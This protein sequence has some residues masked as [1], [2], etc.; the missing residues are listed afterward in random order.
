MART[1]LKAEKEMI[2]IL[3][4]GNKAY[5]LIEGTISIFIASV[6]LCAI[7]ALTSLG[8]KQSAKTVESVLKFIEEKNNEAEQIF[9]KAK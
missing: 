4:H 3:Q 9:S 5:S 1:E 2:R 8:I 6:S 7:L